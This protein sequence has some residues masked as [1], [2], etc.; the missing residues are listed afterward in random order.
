MTFTSVLLVYRQLFANGGTQMIYTSGTP[1]YTPSYYCVSQL[2]VFCV[3][4]FPPLFAFFSMF[5]HCIGS[6]PLI[7]GF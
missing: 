5:R 4:Y 2:L 1:E 7:Y 3:V 6:P